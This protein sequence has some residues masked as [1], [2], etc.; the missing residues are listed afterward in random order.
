MF[1]FVDQ[2]RLSKIKPLIVLIVFALPTHWIF[3]EPKLRLDDWSQIIH[4]HVYEYMKWFDWNQGRPLIW[5]IYKGIIALT[6]LRIHVFYIINFL[7]V[8]GIAFLIYKILDQLL[9]DLHPIPLIAALFAMLY[10]ADYT[11]TWITMINIRLAWLLTLIGMWALLEYATKGGAGHL[12]IGYFGLLL[13]LLNYEGTVGIIVLWCLFIIAINGKNSF[14]NNVFL[15]VPIMLTVFFII[16]KIYLIPKIGIADIYINN[17]DTVSPIQF[18]DR[19]RNIS[20]LFWAWV[21]PLQ[22]LI[23][24]FVQYFPNRWL[25]STIIIFVIFAYMLIVRVILNSIKIHERPSYNKFEKKQYFRNFSGV[26]LVSA[27]FVLLGYIPI[28]SA[29]KPNLDDVS[30]RVNM[31]AIPAAAVVI[32][33]IIS[34]TALIFSKDKK[35]WQ[36]LLL[37]GTFPLIVL[38]MAINITVNHFGQESWVK[39]KE[40]WHQLFDLAPRIKENTTVVFVMNGYYR[41]EHGAHPPLY[42]EWETDTALQVL[43]E[44]ESLEGRIYF[45]G[46]DI[47]SEATFTPDGVED[48]FK[49]KMASYEEVILLKYQPGTEVLKLIYDP[50]EEMGLTF[51]VAN[52]APSNRIIPD[53]GKIWNYRYLVQDDT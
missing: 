14:K 21:I 22:N 41:L 47:Y 39:Q 34:I 18:L 46:I 12:I 28:I 51:E 8:I 3:F 29:F 6:G 36:I 35:Q 30:T 27:G 45:P 5:T 42:A 10:P 19:F 43:Y 31:Y 38:G 50:E 17:P 7:I 37:A 33:V 25:T 16:Y 23:Q 44:D 49:T 2:I 9:P 26:L 52:Y 40:I 1:K 15:L 11:L 24:R 53:T 20:V 48:A 4:P 32:V 13:P